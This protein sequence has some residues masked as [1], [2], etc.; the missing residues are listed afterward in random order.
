MPIKV[1]RDI[2][3]TEGVE[4]IDGGTDKE[5]YRVKDDL[6]CIP[7]KSQNVPDFK[8]IYFCYPTYESGKWFNPAEVDETS[9]LYNIVNSTIFCMGSEEYAQTIRA[10]GF[11]QAVSVQSYNGDI[12]EINGKSYGVSVNTY[13]YGAMAGFVI[14]LE[15]DGAEFLRIGVGRSD[16]SGLMLFPLVQ[17]QYD[18]SGAMTGFNLTH[19]GLKKNNA[20]GKYMLSITASGYYTLPS[21]VYDDLLKDIVEAQPSDEIPKNTVRIYKDIVLMNGAK[22]Y[23]PDGTEYE[24][25]E[26]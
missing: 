3:L 1:Y 19:Y 14:A 13:P 5:T 24:I 22:I 11:P 26:N 10:A 17:A 23:L 21:E 7:V 15:K 20:D 6:W 12:W 4:I 25:S 2:Q 16:I 18:E 9:P 8:G